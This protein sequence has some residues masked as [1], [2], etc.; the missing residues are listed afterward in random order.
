[1]IDFMHRVALALDELSDLAIKATE[2]DYLTSEDWWISALLI[3]SGLLII[4]FSDRLVRW[5]ERV[6]TS[7]FM[8]HLNRLMGTWDEKNDRPINLMPCITLQVEVWLLRFLGVM[9]LL[10]G[11]GFLLEVLS[12]IE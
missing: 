4:A 2:P 3:P 7:A 11:L 1:M 8:R 6:R 5:A 10:F 12:D 9:V